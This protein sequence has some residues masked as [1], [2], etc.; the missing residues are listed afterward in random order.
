MNKL[1]TLLQS[2]S[3]EVRFKSC[4]LVQLVI[5]QSGILFEKHAV[6]WMTYIS[7]NLKVFELFDLFR[8]L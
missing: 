6:S 4:Q 8:D 3:P 7:Q 5:P 1:N 2:K